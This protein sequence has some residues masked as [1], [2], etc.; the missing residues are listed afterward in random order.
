ML[1]SI[2][3]V[4]VVSDLKIMADPKIMADSKI[5]VHVKNFHVG[6]HMGATQI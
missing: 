6:H 5:I 3:M 1:F 2:F 4:G